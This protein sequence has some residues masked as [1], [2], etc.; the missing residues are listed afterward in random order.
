MSIIRI[1]DVIVEKAKSNAVFAS[2]S[3]SN[4]PGYVLEFCRKVLIQMHT[5]AD[6]FSKR[7]DYNTVCSL[8]RILADNIAAINLIYDRQ[9]CSECGLR[10]LLYV[11]GGVG[12]RY[13]LLNE[14]EPKYGG[15]IDK[16]IFE[17]L[18][19]N[20]E[21]AKQNVNEC[22]A[23]CISEIKK[24][25]YY[26]LYSSQID[27]LIR[28]KNWRFKSISKPK[29]SYSW[30]EMYRMFGM[31]TADEAFSYFSQYVHGLSVSNIAFNDVCGF[32][33]PISFAVCLLGWLFGFLRR[34]Y[35]VRIE[36]YT[37]EDI[38]KMAPE[39]FI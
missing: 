33:V 31:K 18:C 2:A 17:A 10:H 32:D 6:V 26:A 34:H 23:Y 13:E 8:V 39:M 37:W 16:E 24:S 29:E 27:E 11:L 1:C 38:R 19:I 20:M 36:D 5:L 25:R 21:I 35:E 12:I 14:R 28:R 15:E 4:A 7:E 3:V 30:K 9:D 22:I